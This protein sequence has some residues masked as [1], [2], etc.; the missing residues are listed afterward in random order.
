M[1][2]PIRCSLYRKD[3][4]ARIVLAFLSASLAAAGCASL[5][6][7]AAEVHAP[8]V[9]PTAGN[10]LPVFTG[11]RAPDS[12]EKAE[13]KEENAGRTGAAADVGAGAPESAGAVS[14]PDGSALPEAEVAFSR[15]AALPLSMVPARGT[16]R[17][18]VV[19]SARRLLGVVRSFDERSFLGHMLIINDALPQGESSLAYTASSHRE[20]ARRSGS[21]LA[22]DKA[23]PGDVVTFPC[24]GECG[25]GATDGVAAGIVEEW[26]AGTLR[27]I[28]YVDGEVRNCAWGKST[29]DAFRI[30]KVEGVVR[31]WP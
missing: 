11:L 8:A 30:P 20:R 1:P 19:A 27:F 10:G 13:E 23:L 6:R 12:R 3:A 9:G 22:T 17:A 14:D 28:A 26:A 7:H 24:P 16:A 25:V 29:G 4:C 2:S 21:W 15:P 18:R 5:P 31:T